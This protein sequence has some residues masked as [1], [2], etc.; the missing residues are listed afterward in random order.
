MSVGITRRTLDFYRFGGEARRT[1][2]ASFHNQAARRKTA[3]VGG[4]PLGLMGR[5]SQCGGSIGR[6]S[7]LK[8]DYTLPS[9]TVAER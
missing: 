5:S 9:G 7:G 2:R 1:P 3:S 6:Y 4:T 8:A